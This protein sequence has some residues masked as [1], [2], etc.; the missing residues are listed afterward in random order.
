MT[1][2]AAIHRQ[3]NYYSNYSSLKI[4]QQPNTLAINAPTI[5]AHNPL[6]YLFT[7]LPFVS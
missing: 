1:G 3:T 4:V 7:Y 6:Q 2:M 5:M